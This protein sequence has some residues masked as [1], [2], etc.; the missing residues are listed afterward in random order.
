MFNKKEYYRKYRN[1]HKD[2][3]N[4]KARERY[5]KNR[6]KEL[7]RCKEYIQKHKNEIK[8]YRNT[9]KYKQKKRIRDAKYRIKNRELCNMRRRLSYQK[10]KSREILR[11]T[12]YAANKRK[13]DINFKL[14]SVIRIRL[15]MALKRNSKS[16]NTA[17][18]L[19]CSI[20]ELKNHLEK[21]FKPGMSWDN[22]G[23]HGWHIDHIIPCCN[24]NL[25]NPEEQKKC[26]HY[27]N[28][29]P[30][31]AEDNLRKGGKIELK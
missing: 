5:L 23:V 17:E 26:F 8:K 4:Q 31:W 15:F 16:S 7:Q 11:N 30:L 13:I 24:F 21:Q 25:S 1:E 3:L 12:V 28:L 20:Q 9:D 10:Y 6:D 19:G 18:L 2:I 27:T 14:L 29:Q 22:H